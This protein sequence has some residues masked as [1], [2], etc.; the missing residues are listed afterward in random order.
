MEVIMIAR[1]RIRRVVLAVAMAATWSRGAVAGPGPQPPAPAGPAVI[2]LKAKPG[3]AAARLPLPLASKQRV[4]VTPPLSN[5]Q[6]QA[7]LDKSGIRLKLP[8][9]NSPT[10]VT[11]TPHN[12]VAQGASLSFLG[13]GLVSA[14]MPLPAERT[15]PVE[16]PPYILADLAQVRIEA[17]PGRRYF[18]AFATVPTCVGITVP[19]LEDRQTD[20]YLTSLGA[21][22]LTPTFTLN[23]RGRGQQIGVVGTVDDSGVLVV[24]IQRKLAPT[25]TGTTDIRVRSQ[26]FVLLNVAI[27]PAT[28]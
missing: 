4:S 11:L 20:S 9:D 7:L 27:M 10:R 15:L 16:A 24:S 14:D 8:P 21:D 26:P 28:D 6:L 5:S 13:G 2:E 19:C 17:T 23:V 12:P 1:T 25:G 18:V 3:I 22:F